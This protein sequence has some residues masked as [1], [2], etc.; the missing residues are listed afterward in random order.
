MKVINLNKTK[1]SNFECDCA[2]PDTK[3]ST[4][5]KSMSSSPTS[6][7]FSIKPKNGKN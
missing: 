3:N 5:K 6:V 1:L 4:V 7:F 2:C